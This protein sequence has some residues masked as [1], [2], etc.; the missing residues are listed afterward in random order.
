MT[1]IK[2][3]I[4]DD[5]LELERLIKQRLRKQVQALEF[6]LVFARNGKEALEKMQSDP[7]IEVVLTDIN[8]PE[9]DGLTLLNKLFQND[10]N[11]TAVV[12][13]AY[14]D[15]KNIR[16]AMH[17]GAFDF[18][19]KP[20]DF[21]DLTITINRTLESARQ[22]KKN[23]NQVQEAQLQ[24]I[25]NEK[26]AALGELVAGVAHEINNPI[27]FIAGNINLSTD[28]VNDLINHLRLYQ[29]TFPEPGPLIEDAAA[30]IDLDYQLEDL[31]KMLSE[32][33]RGAERIV[34][35][36]NSLRTFSRSDTVN[37]VLANIREGL[38]ST[39]MILQHRLKANNNRPAIQ[40]VKEYGQPV[41][42]KCYLGQMNQ[43]FMNIFSNAIDTLDEASQGRSYAEM[44]DAPNTITIVTEAKYDRGIFEIKIKDNGQGMSEEVKARIFD[45]LFTTKAV[46]KG[47]GLGLSISRQIVVD[48]HRGSLSC[49]SVLGEGTEFT[50]AIPL[51]EELE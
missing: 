13:S 19:T 35:I 26:M 24:L 10:R 28:A 44:K 50:I 30:K 7:G 33:K 51:Q 31:P 36:S 47:T 3:L 43:V 20:I 16:T 29:T 2:I 32:M 27:G 4:V 1:P 41:L 45:Q 25:Q 37:K 23:I 18:L 5:E 17:C 40:I 22:M 34:N 6:E 39:L 46:G 12:V 14:D 49:E 42:V 38:D 21:E 9:M 15:M 48:M 11:I 8:M